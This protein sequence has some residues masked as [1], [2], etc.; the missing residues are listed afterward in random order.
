MRHKTCTPPLPPPPLPSAQ[1]LQDVMPS[2]LMWSSQCG[3]QGR[4]RH[5]VAGD[6]GKRFS[7]WD[8]IND[9][10]TQT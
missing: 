8:V 2:I 1:Y 9:V 4:F 6:G 7:V 10:V 5:I 3:T